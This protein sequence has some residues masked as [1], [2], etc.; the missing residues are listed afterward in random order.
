MS[1]AETE[2][3]V[4][5]LATLGLLGKEIVLQ[6]TNVVDVTAT[7]CTSAVTLYVNGFP[8]TSAQPTAEGRV[9]FPAVRLR[10]GVTDIRVEAGAESDQLSWR[11]GETER[12][13]PG[14][15]PKWRENPRDAWFKEARFG[16]FIHWGLYSIPAK[17]EWWYA[18]GDLSSDGYK[19][20]M[21]SFNPTDYDPALWARLAKAAGMKY[22]VFTTRHHD[23]FCM[24]DSHF[25][26]YKITNTPYG[27][28][29]LRMLVEA[30]RAEGLRIGFYHSLPDWTHDGYVDLETPVGV[31]TGKCAPYDS[32]RHAEFRALL[33]NHVNQLTTEYGKVDLMF[34]DYLSK[35]KAEEDYFD[36][37]TLIGICRRNQPDILINDRISYFKDGD[38]PDFDYYTPEITVPN[39]PPL[40]RGAL[41]PWETCATMNDHWGFFAGDENFKSGTTIAAGLVACVSRGG[42]LLLNIGP[43]A[44]GRIPGGSVRGLKELAD[45][46][47]VNG[48]A[49]T[50][51]GPSA[52]NPPFGCAYTQKGRVLYL[53]VL[54]PPMG[55][56]TLEGLQGKVVSATILRTRAA[57][58]QTDFWGFETLRPGE[59][60]LHPQGLVA[61]DV[62]KLALN[63]SK[64]K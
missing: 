39:H 53:H 50:G 6:M 48:E 46:F 3:S 11:F 60:R 19:D 56:L 21:K 27:K 58:P 9:T 22:V 15:R 12:G 61:G 41:R 38:A 62:I 26:D 54:V 42:N 2:M 10:R 28:D 20:L 4:I 36:R 49:I 34:F 43:D 5:L 13:C 14:D 63:R 32:A 40:V 31:K 23:G 29:V 37:A 7:G 35:Y 51:C 44:A 45:W 24:F 8:S 59:L 33:R 55:D 64:G 25:T 30:F 1:V 16:L 18:R 57:V 52:F 17:G 47:A